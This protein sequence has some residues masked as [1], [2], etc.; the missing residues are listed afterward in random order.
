MGRRVDSRGVPTWGLALLTFSMAFAGCTGDDAPLEAADTGSGDAAPAEVTY[1]TGGIEGQILDDEARPVVAAMAELVK[2]GNTTK[3]DAAG[4]Y[5]FSN[6]GPG[7]YELRITRSGFESAGRTVDVVA[8]DVVQANLILTP[9]AFDVPYSDMMLFEGHIVVGSALLDLVTTGTGYGCEVC[10][11]WFNAT[12]GIE[13]IVLEVDAEITVD[14][15]TDDNDFF[16]ELVGETKGGRYLADY[17]QIGDQRRVEGGFPEE[18]DAM[19]LSNYCSIFTVCV[20]QRYTLYVT[21][22]YFQPALEHYTAL[23]EP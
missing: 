8:G 6:L 3:T 1:A 23:P 10:R 11:F 2:T 17:W 12:R 16:F 9:L 20:D 18:G 22:F 21:N 13:M 7:S 14:L 19:Q 15:P 4:R 5:S